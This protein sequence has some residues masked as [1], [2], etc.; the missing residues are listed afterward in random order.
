MVPFQN[1]QLCYTCIA[2]VTSGNKRT[3]AP[4]IGIVVHFSL[5][6]I[7]NFALSDCVHIQEGVGVGVGDKDIRYP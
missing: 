3:K 4:D 1:L 6:A 2:S 5:R 7:I